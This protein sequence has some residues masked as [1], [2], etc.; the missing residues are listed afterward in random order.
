MAQRTRRCGTCGRK[1][2][3]K[4][5]YCRKDGGR[6]VM[7]PRRRAGGGMASKAA[8]SGYPAPVVD[9]ESVRYQQLMSAYKSAGGNAA[10]RDGYSAMISKFA[11]RG[12]DAA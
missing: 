4:D 1:V 11:A 10:L 7:F 2:K 6:A 9:L 5:S 3:K 12:G 8:G